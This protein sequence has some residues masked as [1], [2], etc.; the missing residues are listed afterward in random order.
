MESGLSLPAPG[1]Q[2]PM[3]LEPE[4]EAADQKTD[5]PVGK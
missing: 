1:A 4:S 3:R 5:R 2:L